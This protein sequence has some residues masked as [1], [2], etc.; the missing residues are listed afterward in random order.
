VRRIADVDA[1]IVDKNIETS[2]RFQRGFDHGRD[3]RL[4]GDIDIDGQRLGAEGFD[5]A[6]GVIGF[7]LVPSGN[8]DACARAG[9]TPCHAEADAAI[10]T[11]DD[12]DFAGEIE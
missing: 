2:E 5:V 9:Q 10:A 8:D 4:V 3:G 12:G 11:G 1:G 6:D 7:C